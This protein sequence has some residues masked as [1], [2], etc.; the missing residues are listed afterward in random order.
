MTLRW[1]MCSKF[2]SLFFFTSLHR[3]RAHSPSLSLLRLCAHFFLFLNF[4][5]R[6]LFWFWRAQMSRHAL[7]LS[8]SGCISFHIRLLWHLYLTIFLSWTRNAIMIDLFGSLITERFT[9][10][11]G[12]AGQTAWKTTN[13]MKVKHTT[14]ER[15]RE[16]KR[17]C[18]Q[19][20]QIYFF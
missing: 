19:T 12:R 16:S 18:T 7:T 11:D 8:S 5:P 17:R 3:Q 6:G 2:L 9:I 13:K 14:E 1:I 4:G 10:V 15:E 20:I